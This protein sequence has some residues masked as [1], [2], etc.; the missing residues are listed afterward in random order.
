MRYRDK[1][2]GM[3]EQGGF[4]NSFVVQV[5]VQRKKYDTETNTPAL[6]RQQ[7]DGECVTTVEYGSML[8]TCSSCT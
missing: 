5:T 3:N 2:N 8:F 6:P 4:T 1:K 7:Q